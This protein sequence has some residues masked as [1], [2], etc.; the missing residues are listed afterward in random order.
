MRMEIPMPILSIIRGI[1][2]ILGSSI[3][4]AVPEEAQRMDET[5]REATAMVFEDIV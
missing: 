4:A 1:G 2:S 5:M 3:F